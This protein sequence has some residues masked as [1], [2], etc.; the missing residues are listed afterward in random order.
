MIKASARLWSWLQQGSFRA[1]VTV[2][3]AG[4]AVSQAMTVLAS[5]ILTRLYSP[6]AFGVLAVYT[7][8][9][10]IL[11]V[12]SALR[13]ELAIPLPEKDETA[14]NLLALSLAIVMAMSVLVAA[15]VWLLSDT[16]LAWLD[17][18]AI[19]P[20]LWLL[21]LSVLAIGAYQ[22]LNYW[23]TRKKYFSTIS[24]TLGLRSAAQVIIQVIGGVAALGPGGLIAGYIVS[25]VLG[26]STLMKKSRIPVNMI[27]LR[28]WTKLAKDYKDFPLF[29][30]WSA[31]VD[32]I[33]VQMPAILFAHYFSLDD[34]GFFALTMRVLGLP[35][36]LIG[37]A[38]GQTFYA[39]VARYQDDAIATRNLI[40]RLV[41][42]L[43]IPAFLLLAVIILHGPALFALVF[44]QAWAT[45]GQYAQFLVPWF[46]LAFVSSPL[47]T[48]ALVKGKQKQGLWF[49]G[50][51]TTLRLGGI[52]LGAQYG[53]PALAVI[54]FS[55]AGTIIYLIYLGWILRLAGSS[56][57]QWASQIGRFLLIGLSLVASLW[58][59]NAIVPLQPLV[60]VV[61]SLA[62]LGLF[63]LW[64]WNSSYRKALNA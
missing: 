10:S 22:C 38:V 26:I 39:T 49:S 13:Y 33:G 44:G 34:T 45:G 28:T 37:Q 15:A 8:V 1:N 9:V 25:Q 50:V 20:Y 19:K 16:L 57:L 55:A 58:A 40:E 51:V 11:V 27:A 46:M 5:P 56:L 59:L 54:L 36:T 31:L 62:G 12:I 32:V 52:L 29:S 23:A 63:G 48:F 35:A 18:L 3:A 60:G 14:A 7:S 30:T 2:L 53:S 6:D 24:Y 41:S 64:F 4:T 61:I 42:L 17:S 21:P 47:S 43:F